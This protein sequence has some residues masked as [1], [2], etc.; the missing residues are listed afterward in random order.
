MAE[1]QEAEA[2]WAVLRASV[3]GGRRR[4]LFPGLVHSAWRM[5]RSRDPG[6]AGSG[7]TR[8]EKQEDA[9]VYSL[10]G[11]DPYSICP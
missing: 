4:W 10:V 6:V 7:T 9:F 1:E 11:P 5:E 3:L 2:D 8:N